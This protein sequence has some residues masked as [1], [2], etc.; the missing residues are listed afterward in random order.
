LPL[1]HLFHLGSVAEQMLVF[2]T[3]SHSG[4]EMAN[5]FAPDVPAFLA[6]PCVRNVLY[7][8][9]DVSTA[10]AGGG[11]LSQPIARCE[12]NLGRLELRP[13]SAMKSSSERKLDNSV[14][15]L[16]RKLKD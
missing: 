5:D 16:W 14:L 4:D 7:P 2:E 12:A 6:N 3:V 15:C 11:N 9:R 8:K 10:T 1:R 13:S